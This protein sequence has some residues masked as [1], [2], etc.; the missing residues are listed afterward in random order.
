MVR[1]KRKRGGCFGV[2]ALFRKEK[3]GK[4]NLK[5]KGVSKLSKGGGEFLSEICS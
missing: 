4:R 3:G 1:E 5:A 2:S